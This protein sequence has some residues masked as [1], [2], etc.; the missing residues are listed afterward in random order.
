MEIINSETFR[1]I[2]E[3]EV[4]RHTPHPFEW[5]IV[6]DIAQ[7]SVGRVGNLKGNPPAL[8]IIDGQS[9]RCGILLRRSIKQDWVESIISRIEFGGFMK[10]SEV[11]NSPDLFLRH[12]VLHEL[13]V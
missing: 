8:A 7:W 11:L 13:E 3:I 9:G 10:A 6:E 4:G 5:L 1:E 2:L 12:L